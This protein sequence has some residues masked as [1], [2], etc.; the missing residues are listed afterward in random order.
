[1]VS[2][3]QTQIKGAA[4]VYMFGLKTVQYMKAIGKT[5]EKKAE[6]E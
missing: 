6:E 1:M 5:V 3:I 2:E 4:K